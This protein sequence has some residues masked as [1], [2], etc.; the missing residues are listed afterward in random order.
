[1][2]D[3]LFRLAEKATRKVQQIILRNMIKQI[4][5]GNKNRDDNTYSF[6]EFM[7]IGW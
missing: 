7:R 5:L 1:M 6:P 2:Q 3:M 4:W